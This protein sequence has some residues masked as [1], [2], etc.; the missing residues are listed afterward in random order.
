VAAYTPRDQLFLWL[1]SQPAAPVL[2]GTLSMLR[3]SRGVSLRYADEWLARGFALSE[4][5][6]LLA[7]EFLPR[8]KD[9]AAGAVDDARPDRWGERVS[10]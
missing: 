5:L 7:E 1:V 3:A 10:A 9:T 2:I 8:E 6:P 4:D